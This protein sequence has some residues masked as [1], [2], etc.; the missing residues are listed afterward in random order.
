M[1]AIRGISNCLASH[2]SSLKIVSQALSTKGQAMNEIKKTSKGD[3]SLSNFN[4]ELSTAF[5]KFDPSS[6]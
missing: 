5:R 4:I 3:A 6:L 2:L 1:T